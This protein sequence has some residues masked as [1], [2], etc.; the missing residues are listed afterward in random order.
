MLVIARLGGVENY[1]AELAERAMNGPANVAAFSE[2]GSR[3]GVVLLGPPIAA[4]P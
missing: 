3:Y 4:R 1:F 2:I